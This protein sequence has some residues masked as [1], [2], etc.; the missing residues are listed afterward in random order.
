[1]AL[2]DDLETEVTKIFRER[3]TTR[4]GQVVPEPA[5]LK[6]G[7][8]GVRLDATVLYADMADSTALVD[9]YKDWFAAEIYKAFLMCSA[10]IIKAHS[11]IITAY[12]GDRIMAVYIGKTKN[13]AAVKTALRINWAVEK[14]IKLKL[15]AKYADTAYVP[16]HSVGVDT[17]KILVARTGVRNDNDLVWVGRAANYAAKLSAFR[18]DGYSSWIT[19]DVYDKIHKDAKL[20]GDRNMWEK[21]VWTSMNK[22]RIFRSN[23]HWAPD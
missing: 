6:L 13:T 22:M 8:D 12:D 9:G 7:N 10:R 11:G 14:V 20:S 1:M 18:T 17:S 23:W 19:G 4:D 16:A 15:T 3:W 5:D 2:K 21:R